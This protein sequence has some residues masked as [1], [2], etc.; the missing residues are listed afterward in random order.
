MPREL[1]DDYP[2][3]IIAVMSPLAEGADRLVAE[4][5]LA[6]GMPLTVVLPMPREMYAQDF[7]TA[8][9][10]AAVRAALCDAAGDVFELPLTPGNTARPST[11]KG[12]SRARQYAHA[13][14]FLCAHCHV[15]LALWDGKETDQLGGTSQVVRFHH[16]DV[17]PGYTPRATAS[18][19]ILTDDESDLVHHIVCSR[20]RPGRRSRPTG[21]MPLDA[22]WY[23]TDEQQPRV[24]EMPAR[25]R[26]VFD[27]TNEFS[28]E[29]QL[30][31]AEIDK[32]RYSL[33]TG[34]Q[35]ALLPPGL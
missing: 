21:L 31:A 35:A 11:S 15:L 6:L 18:R 34:E 24:R 4:V 26:M 27:R 10:Q 20:D 8:E 32:E 14:V 28:R 9:S 16:H 7:T 17:M 25:H 22:C 30:H 33:L 19:L 2:G 3:R 29:A 12:R 23:T 1:R 13:G 5:A